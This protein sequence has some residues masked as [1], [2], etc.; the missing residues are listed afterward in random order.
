M[1]YR[2]IPVLVTLVLIVIG[3]ILKRLT[4]LDYN[5]RRDFTIEFRDNFVKM[6]NHFFKTGKFEP[7][8]YGKVANDLNAI[9]I[10]VG[11]DGIISEMVD[12]LKGIK[13][14]DYQIFMN[15]IPE[16]R[17][18]SGTMDMALFAGRLEQ[19]IGICDDS[20][21]RHIGVLSKIID[22][23]KKYLW[24][25]F[26][27]FGEGIRWLVGLPGLLFVWL[28]II[29]PY[30]IKAAQENVLFKLVGSI[31]TLVGFLGSIIT[32]L[33]GWE[34]TLTLLNKLLQR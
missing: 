12:P 25:P 10:E 20:L 11:A 31:I 32:I 6:A 7:N 21:R 14:R 13:V 19:M 27:C 8:S 29:K 5:K 33:L 28:G 17:A 15:I 30:R 26:S 1:K 3:H 16:M 9:Q 22:E 18:A 24:N 2:L 4:L 23:Q 34:E